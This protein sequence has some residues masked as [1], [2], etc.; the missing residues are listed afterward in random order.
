MIDPSPF[1]LILNSLYFILPAYFANMCPIIFKWIPFGGKPVN[2]GLFGSHKTW[3]GFY[4]GYIGALIILALQFYLQKK[5]LTIPIN[6]DNF[7][8]YSKNNAGTLLDY[9]QINIFF[10]AF[11]FGIGAITGDTLKSFF[12]RRLKIAPGQPWFPFDQLDFIVGALVF[13]SPFYITPWKN[14]LVIL[15][16]TP[17]LHFL[18]NATAYLL[19]LKKVWW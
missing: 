1:N 5:G 16:I 17:L 14:T 8:F 3:R 18:A 12:K 4:V 2:E 13:L 19:R 11:L 9:E 6:P 15:I 7:A 10:Y